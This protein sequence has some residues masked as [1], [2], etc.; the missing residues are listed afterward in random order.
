MVCGAWARCFPNTKCVCL[1]FAFIVYNHPARMA[2][3]TIL[4][5]N[6]YKFRMEPIGLEALELERAGIGNAVRIL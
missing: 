5:R 3:T 1:F 6:V 2:A 4:C